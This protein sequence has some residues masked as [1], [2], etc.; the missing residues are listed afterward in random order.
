M[1]AY[2]Y[3]AIILGGGLITKAILM[4][5]LLGGL[6]ALIAFYFAYSLYQPK[7]DR[8][9]CTKQVIGT[10]TA[11]KWNRF[12]LNTEKT[13]NVTVQYNGINKT[14]KQQ[15]PSFTH[16][17]NVGNTISIRANPNNLKESYLDDE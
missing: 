3:F 2:T 4:D 16:R 8:S 11:I 7:T 10:I 17:F 15:P 5:D 13:F 14:F 12:R 1:N 6:W 9:R